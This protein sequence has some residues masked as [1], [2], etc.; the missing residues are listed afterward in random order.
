MPL[1]FR[2]TP[3]NQ[4]NKLSLQVQPLGF[5]LTKNLMRSIDAELQ[6]KKWTISH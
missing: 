4:D 1:I 3:F 2:L 6:H 5:C